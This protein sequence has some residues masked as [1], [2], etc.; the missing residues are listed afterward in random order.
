[1]H[2]DHR[3]EKDNKRPGSATLGSFGTDQPFRLDNKTGAIKN[4]KK[5]RKTLLP[6]LRC[7]NNAR[8]AIQGNVALH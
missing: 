1:M 6:F 5:G 7:S 2:V 8:D 3:G 4:V